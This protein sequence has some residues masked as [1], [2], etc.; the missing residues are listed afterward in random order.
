MNPQPNPSNQLPNRWTDDFLN[1]MRQVTDPV[2][3]QVVAELFKQ[4]DVAAVNDLMMHLVKDDQVIPDQLPPVVKNY[5][6]AQ[7]SLP[8]WADQRKL[9]IAEELFA[10]YG[11]LICLSLLC[12]SLPECYA[13][14][15]GVHVLRFTARLKTDTQRRIAETA[16]MVIDVNSLGGLGPDGNGIRT[17]QKVRLMHATIRNFL[18]GNKDWNSDWGQPINQEDMAMTMMAFSFT[19]IE[20]LKKFGIQVTPEQAEAYLHSWKVVGHLLGLRDEM[21]PENMDDAGALLAAIHRRQFEFSDDGKDMAE[22]LVALME[23]QLPGTFFD[24]FA[25]TLIR[26]LLGDEMGDLLRLPQTDW[27]KKL[28]GPFRELCGLEQD[29]VEESVVMRKVVDVAGREFLKG[30]VWLERGGTRA[31]FK[32]PQHLR[33]RW[34]VPVPARFRTLQSSLLAT[35]GHVFKSLLTFLLGRVT[36]VMLVPTLA[37]LAILL[38]I[39]FPLINATAP[40]GMFSLELAGTAEQAQAVISSWNAPSQLRAIFSLG[41]G[42]ILLQLFPLTIGLACLWA[43]EGLRYWPRWLV[44]VGTRLALGQLLVILLWAIQSALMVCLLLGEGMNLW[45]QLILLLA[46]GKY[47]LMTAGLMYALLGGFQYISTPK[48][49]VNQ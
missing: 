38:W 8:P 39:T 10:D 23:N 6:N 45:P 1:S 28:I 49:Q 14:A 21:L 42:F 15:R 41:L 5:L 43:A 44:S 19:V 4:R 33:E 32:I 24:G 31:P 7:F 46:T 25:P 9:Q 34:H 17:V 29:E 20:C 16:Q 2:A 26:Y 18:T 3:D 47:A 40:L 35:I 22:A 13:N 11:M 12:A 30:L 36:L 48:D 27:T 37:L